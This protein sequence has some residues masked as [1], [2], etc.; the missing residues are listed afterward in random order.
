[1]NSKD[2]QIL[3]TKSN[4]RAFYTNYLDTNNLLSFKVNY[5]S[6][7]Q[8]MKASINIFNGIDDD[9]RA[10]N[11]EDYGVSLLYELLKITE[12]VLDNNRRV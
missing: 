5:I 9:F 7:N 2:K 10:D 3:S 8:E 11:E 6:T 4:I 1:M 12:T